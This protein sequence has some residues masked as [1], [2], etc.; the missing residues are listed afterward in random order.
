M[1]IDNNTMSPPSSTRFALLL[2]GFLTAALVTTVIVLG[3]DADYVSRYANAYSSSDPDPP[4]W[5]TFHS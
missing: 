1:L 3:I 4:F 5:F 2:S